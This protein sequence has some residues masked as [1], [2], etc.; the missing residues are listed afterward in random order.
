MRHFL[1]TALA[2]RPVPS[3]VALSTQEPVPCSCTSALS[4]SHSSS[5][6]PLE[7]STDERAAAEVEHGVVALDKDAMMAAWK[8][9]W[10]RAKLRPDPPASTPNAG[11]WKMAGE[12]IRPGFANG[13][14]QAAQLDNAYTRS[15]RLTPGTGRW[16]N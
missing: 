13:E 3:I 2:V 6:H 12:G 8:L 5:D 4:R 16:N 1:S 10:E 15:G 14:R 7:R 11:S 9:E